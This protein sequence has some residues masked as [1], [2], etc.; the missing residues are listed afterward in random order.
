MPKP[1]E[2]VLAVQQPTHSADYIGF[3]GVIPQGYGA[4][5]VNIQ[6]RK[7]AKVLRSSPERITFQMGPGLYTLVKTK[8]KGD[9]GWLLINRT[10]VPQLGKKAGAGVGAGPND[11]VG[12]AL[13]KKLQGTGF[14]KAIEEIRDAGKRPRI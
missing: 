8:G 3:K 7:K 14:Q 11:I 6:S 13:A 1:G 12:M 4:G 9:R 5:P 2:K 10:Q